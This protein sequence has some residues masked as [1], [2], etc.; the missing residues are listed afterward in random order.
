M[1]RVFQQLIN[2]SS[3]PTQRTEILKNASFLDR[4][5]D[6]LK[7]SREHDLLVICD[8]V[9]NI[10]KYPNHKKENEKYDNL[11]PSRLFYLDKKDDPHY[12]GQ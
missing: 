3:K 4:C 8:D 9:Y 7:I 6:L 2:Q 10:F 5:E 1:S 12:K 11:S